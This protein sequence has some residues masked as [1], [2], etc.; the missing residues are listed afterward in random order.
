MSVA[1]EVCEESVPIAPSPQPNSRE[2]WLP[3]PLLAAL[4]A[5][6][7]ALLFRTPQW[8]A[9]HDL[10]RY[11]VLV[12][13]FG[14]SFLA[15]NLYP[16]WLP[17]LFGGYGYPTFVY[18]QPG[19]F[20]LTLPFY[21]LV[22]DTILA[23]K[24]GITTLLFGGVYGFYLLARRLADWRTALFAAACFGMTPYIYVNLYVR[25]DLSEL[26]AMLLAPWPLYFLVRTARPRNGARTPRLDVAGMTVALAAVIASHPAVA[27]CYLPAFCLFALGLALPLRRGARGLAAAAIAVIA[28]V[29]L[30]APYWFMTLTMKRHV[31]FERL[32]EGYNQARSHTVQFEQLFSRLWGFG[33]STPNSPADGMSFQ[34][35][36]PLCLLALGGAWIGRRDRAV[37]WAFAIYLLLVAAMTPLASSLWSIPSPYQYLQFPWRLLSTIAVF[38]ALVVV[39]LAGLGGQGGNGHR[40]AAVLALAWG[41]LFVWSANQFRLGGEFDPRLTVEGRDQ[42]MAG[43]KTFANSNEFSPR[44]ADP[45]PTVPR[46]ANR[47]IVVPRSVAIEPGPGHGVHSLDYRIESPHRSTEIFIQQLYFPGWAVE[48]DGRPVADVE[49][50]NTRLPDGRM[51]VWLEGPGSHRLVARY[52]G[53]PGQGRLSAISIGWILLMA[54]GLARFGDRLVVPHGPS[55]PGAIDDERQARTSLVIRP[56]RIST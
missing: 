51:R 48:I 54:V 50:R 38:Q 24:L 37:R 6:G 32:I 42:R 33:S 15:G 56:S 27:I 29:A 31:H 5:V 36:L 16:R 20:F 9:S 34:L 7:V 1:G 30:T 13:A 22:P 28:S 4:T 39:G 2:R 12:D 21:L 44:T 49:L 10:D 19:Y 53:P 35:G 3:L 41:L 26:A 45:P 52:A 11:P 40:H 8:I 55:D 14:R 17:D 46:E 47:M 43:F 18:Y 23:L 25:G